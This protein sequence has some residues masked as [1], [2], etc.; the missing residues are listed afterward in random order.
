V[1]P[2]AWDTDTLL[3]C[4]TAFVAHATPPP[5]KPSFLDFAADPL[6]CPPGEPVRIPPPFVPPALRLMIGD[7]NVQWASPAAQRGGDGDDGDDCEE[8]GQLRFAALDATLAALSRCRLESFS[9]YRCRLTRR[10]VPALC[11][12]LRHGGL[13]QL[14]LVGHPRLLK[15]SKRAPPALAQLAAALRA[16]PRLSELTLSDLAFA[17]QADIAT[18]IQACAGHA[19]LSYLDITVDSADGGQ[20]DAV[21]AAAVGTAL[22]ALV[23]ARAPPLLSLNLSGKWTP[24]QLAPLCAA[25]ARGGH[26]IEQAMC[27]V[28]DDVE[29]AGSRMLRTALAAGRARQN[30]AAQ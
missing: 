9:A 24:P 29:A 25:L 7:V 16:A 30:G 4:I 26:S 2:A 15:R 27:R 28:G 12:L 8:A 21:A 1:P 14:C 17:C 13:V 11:S 22:A 19:T 3:G 10:F 18:L 23:D 6:L 20:D 5:A